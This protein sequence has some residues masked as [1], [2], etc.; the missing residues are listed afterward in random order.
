VDPTKTY[1]EEPV[2]PSHR[3]LQAS[4]DGPRSGLLLVAALHGAFGAFAGQTFAGEA[5]RAFARHGGS[6]WVCGGGCV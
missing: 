4:F 5:F 6:V 2:D 1:L 3:E